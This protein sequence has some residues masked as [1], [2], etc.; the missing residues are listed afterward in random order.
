VDTSK[1][2]LPATTKV[3]FSRDIQPILDQSCI[4]CHGPERP[5]SHFRLDNRNSAIKG[6]DNG[7]DIIP[8]NSANSPLIHYVAGLVEDTPMPP[9]GKAEPLTA[10][11]I[12]LLRAWIDQGANWSSVEPTNTLA[13]SFSPTLRY[14]TVSGNEQQFRS[15]YWQREGW[16]G[17]VEQFE[18]TEQVKPDTK[19]IT[20]GHV[21]LDDYD[22]RLTLQKD[23]VGFVRS[24]WVQYRKYYSD[25]GGFYPTFTPQV[26][27]LN[28]D[29]HLDIGSAWIDF[30]LTLP[31]WPQMVFGYEY[32]YR[33][34]NKSTLE[35]G[36]VVQGGIDRKIAPASE[37]L[38]ELTHILKFDLD[39]EIQGV[40]IEDNFRGEFYSLHT[41]DTNGVFFPAVN[42]FQGNN[43]SEG[44]HHFQGANVL[45]AEKQFNDWLFGSAG[46]LYSKLEADASF[47]IDTFNISGL[48]LPEH[49]WRG[50]DIELE[51]KS[52][53]F[54]VS[55]LL[56]PWDGLS[57]SGGVQNEYT[58]QKGFGNDNL[59][60]LFGGNF[61]F[62]VPVTTI[63]D[64]DKASVEENVSVRYTKIPFTA[65]FAEARLRQQSIGQFEEET[66]GDQEFLRN[67]DFSNQLYDVRAGFHTSPWQWMALSAHYRRY[68]DDSRYN[69]T[70]DQQPIG[71]PGIGYS[72]FIRARDILTDEVEAKL[73]LRVTS[74]LKTTLSYKKLSTDYHTTTDPVPFGISPGGG[75]LAGE[76]DAHIYS[77]N[78]TLT[79]YQRLYFVGTFSYQDSS[80]VTADNG[81]PSIVPYHGDVYSALASAT[82][83]LNQATDI[84]G[85]YVFSY[86]DYSQGNFAAG[87]PVGIR[88]Q[89]HVIQGGLTHRF[90]K[91]LAAKL[92]YAYFLYDEPTSGTFNNYHGQG[93]FGTFTYRFQ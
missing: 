46:Y 42:T 56:G 30:G 91:N 86:A 38:N 43:D 2:P 14:I 82:Y 21:L 54:N 20:S 63:S 34:G 88:Y 7:V 40:H 64:L 58:R 55:T 70:L 50:P 87:L 48:P 68:D 92:Q 65:L 59:D 69:N 75:L 6:G 8:G 44:Y 9:S 1:L 93:I 67:T 24:G 84:I 74:W 83:A 37:S 31:D 22:L 89:Q 85:T 19:V 26:F 18:L 4:R 28:R 79:P 5:K 16:N 52:H 33:I 12:A 41:F 39:Y 3:D 47:S 35:W 62:P 36:D 71:F 23:D 25:T 53:I 13:F 45:R 49:R 57:I 27:S 73:A 10:N 51:R 72:A 61:F 80:T 60:E 81:N 76:S 90:N 15:H 78:A 66:G 17:G 11:Q 32:Q 77:L 29:L